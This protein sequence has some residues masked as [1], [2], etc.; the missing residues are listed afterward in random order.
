MALLPLIGGWCQAAVKPPHLAFILVDDMGFE[1]FYQS[2]DLAAA[3]PAT[4]KLA[5]SSC[6]SVEHYYT[7]PVCTPTRGAFMTGRYPVRL[8]LQHAAINSAQPYGLPLEE[9]TLPEK[10]KAAGYATAGFGK[11]HL[12]IYNNASLPTRR[13]FDHWYG[14]WQGGET[15]S[16][17][18]YPPIPLV[19]VID[20]NDD[21]VIDRSKTGVYSA[22]LFGMK[23]VERIQQHAKEQPTVP[24][25]LYLALQNVHNPIESPAEY[26]ARPGCATI[27]NKNRKV[28]CGMVAA[29]DDAVANVT[30]AFQRSFPGEDTVVVIGGDNGGIPGGGGSL[31]GGGGSN[32]PDLSSDRC[33]RGV[34]GMVWEGGFRNNALICSDTLLPAARHGTIY[35]QGLVHVMDWH[36]TFL[37]LAGVGS[38]MAAKPLDGVSVWSA[39]LADGPSPRT[40]FLVNIDP[41]IRRAVRTRDIPSCLICHSDVWAH[42]SAV[43]LFAY[44]VKG[45]M[46]MTRAYRFRG[47]IGEPEAFCGDWK[48]VDTPVN[49]SWYPTPTHIST[50]AEV[51]PPPTLPA[52]SSLVEYKGEWQSPVLP[53]HVGFDH[54]VGLY[55]LTADPGEHVNLKSQ[56]PGVVAALVRKIEALDAVAMKPCNIPGGACE[57]QDLRG[58][59]QA[60][61]ERGWKPWVKDEL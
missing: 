6:V 28:F 18:L 29:A 2:S 11:W 37:E 59:L 9:V 60:E 46:N 1:D 41:G 25:F 7:Q 34:K 19:G 23:A 40:E 50:P 16:T 26:Q 58:L 8:G 33:L 31:H 10:L 45:L 57:K 32:C 39:L 48:Y 20:L 49:A 12:G 24:L 35:K 22:E 43:D 36:A 42:L 52:I 51:S 30:T 17:H 53:I 4:S 15:H 14:F 3:W 61:L 5:S 47:C 56:F 13:G 54:V 44:A 55:N 38:V 21:E 27:P